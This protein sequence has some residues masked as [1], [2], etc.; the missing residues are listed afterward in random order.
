MPLLCNIALR[1]K[2]YE[3]YVFCCCQFKSSKQ[4]DYI[5]PCIIITEHLQDAEESSS[6]DYIAHNRYC[7]TNETSF[8]CH[9]WNPQPIPRV[10]KIEDTFICVKR[11]K[12]NYNDLFF[13]ADKECPKGFKLC[14]RDEKGFLCLEESK[15]CP[16]NKIILTKRDF[17]WGTN[18]FESFEVDAA[19]RKFKK[20]SGSSSAD[21]TPVSNVSALNAESSNKNTKKGIYLSH[22][23]SD[24]RSRFLKTTGSN[25]DIYFSNKFTESSIIVDF[26][27]LPETPKVS[28]DFVSPDNT[29]FSQHKR[30]HYLKGKKQIN[31]E[32]HISQ[33]KKKQIEKI[34]EANKTHEI[35]NRR[36]FDEPCFESLFPNLYADSTQGSRFQELDPRYSS[37]G[38]FDMSR[39]FQ[40]NKVFDGDLPKGFEFLSNRQ[41]VLVT[42]GYFGFDS[43]CYNRH[44]HAVHVQGHGRIEIK[45][46]RSPHEVPAEIAVFSRKSD[47]LGFLRENEQVY[48]S[49]LLMLKYLCGFFYIF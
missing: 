13:S 25:F 22:I 48:D 41:L 2:K 3:Q 42:R 35:F 27:L 14:G 1:L 20:V 4:I 7:F 11:A 28:L 47:V 49:L 36:V 12:Y 6:F 19:R 21:N 33:K 30:F 32:Q 10:D 39:V 24:N 31:R 45:D 44:G 18:S 26:K 8:G 17:I 37:L 29:S 38:Q 16:I 5:L 43:K 40:E 34:K 46:N 9:N 15:R 23:L